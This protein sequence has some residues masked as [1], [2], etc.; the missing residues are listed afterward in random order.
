MQCISTKDNI[1]IRSGF[2]VIR[3]LLAYHII[4]IWKRI[5]YGEGLPK[6]TQ[7]KLMLKNVDTSTNGRMDRNKY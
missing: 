7:Y 5:D 4:S 1:S 3:Q 6:Y 2:L